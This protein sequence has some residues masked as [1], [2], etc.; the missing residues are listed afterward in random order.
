MCWIVKPAC[1]YPAAMPR[2]ETKP[3]LITRFGAD[4]E[5]SGIESPKK[6]SDA[7]SSGP[8]NP[9]LQPAP[10]GRPSVAA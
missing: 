7:G 10:R 9:P 4:P 2:P 8:A 3:A 5:T 6:P 1:T